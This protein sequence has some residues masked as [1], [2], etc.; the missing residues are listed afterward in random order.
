MSFRIFSLALEVQRL[1]TN[2]EKVESILGFRTP[3]DGA[4]GD[5][6]TLMAVL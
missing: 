2:P 5:M 6:K 3:S 4:W 1:V